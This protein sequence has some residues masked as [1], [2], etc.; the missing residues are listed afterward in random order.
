MALATVQSITPAG[1][2][3]AYATPLSTEQ[4]VPM[5]RLFLHV[6]NASGGSIN[7]TLTDPS[8]TPA[9]SVATN[10]V[11]AVPAAGERMIFLSPNLASPATGTIQAAFSA[12]ASV[13]AALIR[14]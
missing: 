14:S 3:P 1:L 6:K 7:V 10:P 11:I 5:D 2:N 8:L 13:T 12:T 4:I 9:G